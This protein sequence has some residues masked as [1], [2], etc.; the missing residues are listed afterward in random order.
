[1]QT[2]EKKPGN[3][4]KLFKVFS[5]QQENTA[6]S[7]PSL[8]SLAESKFIPQKPSPDL[9]KTSDRSRGAN[10]PKKASLE[11]AHDQEVV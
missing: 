7:P 5:I 10:T 6:P 8:Q 3:Y 2:P 11:N 1:M 4:S 9:A